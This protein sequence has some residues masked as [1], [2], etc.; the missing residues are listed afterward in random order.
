MNQ[1]EMSENVLVAARAHR[2][3]VASEGWK[4]FLVCPSALVHLLDFKMQVLHGSGTYEVA[5]PSTVDATDQK[6][7]VWTDSSDGELPPP[8]ALMGVTHRDGIL[9]LSEL[10]FVSKQPKKHTS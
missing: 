1:L 5:T 7:L 4:E 8:H 3:F 10:R 9:Q 6:L 2:V